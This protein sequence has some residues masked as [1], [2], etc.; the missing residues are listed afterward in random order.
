[1]L[2]TTAHPMF[3]LFLRTYRLLENERQP[4]LSPALDHYFDLAEHLVHLSDHFADD[5]S[6]RVVGWFGL[7]QYVKR[8][9]KGK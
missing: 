7:Y 9:W 8:Q 5:V 6:L 4:M 1:M 3:T 2:L